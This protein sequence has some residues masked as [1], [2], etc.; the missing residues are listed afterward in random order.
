MSWSLSSMFDQLPPCPECSEPY[1]YVQ[2]TLLVCPMCAY[3]WTLASDTDDE[4]LSEASEAI[5]DAVGNPLADGDAVTVVKGLK[6]AGSGGGTIKV[7]TKAKSIRLLDQPVNGHDIEAAVPG[8]G[9]IY[10]K[11]SV[12]KKA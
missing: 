8:L 12:V 3:E 5:R 4:S 7:G 1:T 6:I 10:L 2:G 11:S 9:R